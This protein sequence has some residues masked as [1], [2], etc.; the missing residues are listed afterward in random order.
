MA[1][2]YLSELGPTAKRCVISQVKRVRHWPPRAVIAADRTS[3][4]RASSMWWG[5]GNKRNMGNGKRTSVA[6]ATI[7]EN[8]PLRDSRIKL[9][10]IH[11]V[12]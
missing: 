1:V 11:R 8:T 7:P 2:S 9:C 6:H 5:L 10:S 4:S 12:K 3:R